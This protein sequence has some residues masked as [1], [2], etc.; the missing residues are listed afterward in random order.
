MSANVTPALSVQT[1]DQDS[2]A[3]KAVLVHQL[4]EFLY[5]RLP[6]GSGS[7]SGVQ[8]LQEIPEEYATANGKSEQHQYWVLTLYAHAHI[9]RAVYEVRLLE[10]IDRARYCLLGKEHTSEGRPHLQCYVQFSAAK[11]WRWTQ[12]ISFTKIKVNNVWHSIGKVD[13]ARGD[14]EENYVYCTKELDFVEFGERQPTGQAAMVAGSARGGKK[15]KENLNKLLNQAVADVMDGK[16]I[17]DAIAIRY[18]GIYNRVAQKLSAMVPKKVQC[19]NWYIWGPAGT[20]KTSLQERSDLFGT[21]IFFKDPHTKWYDHFEF[22]TMYDT[23]WMDEVTPETIV[24]NWAK[25]NQALDERPFTAE[26]KGSSFRIR[27]GRYVLTSNY[28]LDEVINQLKAAKGDEAAY[29]FQRRFRHV[30]EM[31][32]KRYEPRPTKTYVM[33]GDGLKETG[34]MELPEP[35]GLDPGT[36]STADVGRQIRRRILDTPVP[37]LVTPPPSPDV[38]GHPLVRSQGIAVPNLVRTPVNHASIVVPRTPEPG[39]KQEPTISV[40]ETQPIEISDDEE[41]EDSA[42]V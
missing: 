18:P 17:E 15:T 19:D 32:G 14:D 40:P 36:T 41:E 24:M 2:A 34:Y 38:G 11:R 22:W 31:K 39:V 33:D 13:L 23:V 29:A 6:A 1:T 21:K 35:G 5:Q 37:S 12:A 8:P 28:S 27:P 16:E 9:A 3:S 10:L 26:A 25:L 7:G 30:V 42:E 4:V 20:G